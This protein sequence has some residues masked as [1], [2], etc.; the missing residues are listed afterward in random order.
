MEEDALVSM[1]SKMSTL[2]AIVPLKSRNVNGRAM[3]VV[4]R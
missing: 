2:V 1:K 3:A 4:E